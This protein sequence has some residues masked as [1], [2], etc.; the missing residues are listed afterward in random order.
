MT[1][2]WVLGG[3]GRVGRGV[4]DRLADGGD[5]PVLVGR[6][7]GRLREAAAARGHRTYVAPTLDAATAGIREARP[8][9]VVST[10]GPFT[11][12]MTPVVDACLAAGS[13]YVDL[14]NDLAAVPALLARGEDAVRAGRTLVT[15]AGFGVAA[16]ESVVAW[17]CAEGRDAGRRAVRVRTDMVPS[18][19]LQSGPLGEALAGTL[20]EGL[21]GV[22]GGGRFQGRRFAD[23]RLTP[24]PLGGGVHPLVTP[25]GDHVSAGLMPLGELVAA[26]RASGAPDV[27]SAS[28]EV[29]HSQLAR[30]VLPA[31]S[32]LLAVGPLR[33]FAARRLAA[34]TFPARPAPRTH[35]WGHAVVTWDDGTTSEGWLG[36]GEAQ[37]TTDALVTEVARRLLRG[38]GRP[39]AFTPAALFGAGLATA[40]GGTY[41]RIGAAA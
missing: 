11:R 40:V 33:R 41:T 39:G 37:E 3:T 32:T 34:V 8:T 7:A 19:A 29:P 1:E 25:D 27:E 6:D 24:A 36:L 12:T 35:S 16:T 20:M 31:A 38:D 13:D 14:A 28:S 21:P 2:I 22:S 17:L 10:V 5:S 9:V 23:G 26:Q 4:A 18:L 30:L 15:G